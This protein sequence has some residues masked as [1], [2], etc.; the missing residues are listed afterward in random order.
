LRSAIEIPPFYVR[1]APLGYRSPLE[2]ATYLPASG[3]GE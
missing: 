3:S 2:I 1:V